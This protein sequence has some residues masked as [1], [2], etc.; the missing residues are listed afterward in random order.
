MHTNFRPVL[1]K[2]LIAVGITLVAVRDFRG[3]WLKKKKKRTP[4]FGCSWFLVVLASR[5]PARN[6]KGSL[7][8]FLKFEGPR[9][10]GDGGGRPHAT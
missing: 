6:E 4:A 5:E 10:V 7:K 3:A 9:A 8:G 2:V 1:H